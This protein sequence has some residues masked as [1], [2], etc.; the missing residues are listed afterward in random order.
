M[1]EKI[2]KGT[3]MGNKFLVMSEKLAF[4]MCAIFNGDFDFLM[5]EYVLFG[6]E[7]LL[8]VYNP[9]TVVELF[10]ELIQRINTYLDMGLT[11]EKIMVV[12]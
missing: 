8:K 2:I 12:I 1:D 10:P 6:N 5:S 4:G 3:I 11:D 9:S 7:D